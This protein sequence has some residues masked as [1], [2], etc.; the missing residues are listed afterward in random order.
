MKIVICGGRE[1]HNTELFITE[2]HSILEGK[3]NFTLVSGGATGADTL[4]RKYAQMNEYPFEEYLAEWDNL[5]AP[6]AVVKTNKKTG[7]LYNAR[8]GHD[9]NF[10]LLDMADMIVAFWD[11]ISPGTG[12][13]VREAKKRNIPLV[14]VSY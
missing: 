8:A 2:M 7:K 12:E 1:F 5:D 11:G 9:R 3:E 14:I 13:M 4:A 6:G 10:V